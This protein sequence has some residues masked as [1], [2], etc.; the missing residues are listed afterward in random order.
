MKKKQSVFYPSRVRK[1]ARANAAKFSWASQMSHDIVHQAQPWLGRTDDE[2]WG[3]MFGNTIPRS[4]MVWSNGYCPA[5][6]EGVPMYNWVIDALQ[7]PWKV[8]CPHCRELFP[9]NDFHSF[10]RSG[11]DASG[12]FD[13]ER[14]DRTLLFNA[15]HPDPQDP[16][17]RFGVDEGRGYAEGENRW[18]FIGA[19]LIYGQWKQAVH[20]GIKRLAAAYVLSGDPIY[21]HKAGV[22]LDRVADLYPTFDGE[23]EILAYER[24]HGPGYVSTWHDA[25]VETRDLVLAY[26]QIFDAL[27][28]DQNLVAFLGRKAREHSLENPKKCI[29][30][31]QRNIEERILGDAL[32]NTLAMRPHNRHK[33]MCN[34]P[35]TDITLALIEMV[36]GWPTNRQEVFARVDPMIEQATSVDGL[37]G[38]K[39]LTGYSTFTIHGLA[40]FLEEC[41]RLDETILEE[42]LDRHPQL[43]QTYRFHIDTWCL[44]KYYPLVGDGGGFGA[45][46]E[47]YQG[48]R[49]HRPAVEAEDP[50]A[51]FDP[52]LPVSM[53]SLLWR[54]YRSTGDAAFIQI[55]Y[56]ANGNSVDGLPHDLLARDPKAVQ[57]ET[58]AVTA[59][60]GAIP[61]A[62]SINKERWHLAILRSGRGEQSRAAWV[63]YCRRLG[64]GH[65]DG[66]NLGLF[67]KGLDLMPDFGY[68]PVQ[69]GGWNSPRAAWYKMSAAHNTVV[70]DGQDQVEG[71]GVTTLWAAGGHFRAI[72]LSGAELIGGRQFERTVVAVDISER[73]FY[74][75]DLFRVVGGTDHA[76]FMHSH[77]G[78]IATGGLSLQPV[79]EYGHGTQMRRFLGDA[80]PQ[81]G[82]SVDWRVEDRFQYLQPGVDL[83]LRYTD[84]T[85]GAQACTCEG[86]IHVGDYHAQ[87]DTWIPR[88][89]VRR[90]A[91]QAPLASTF[92]GLI[93][94]YETASA[95][96][97]VRRLP[98]HTPAGDAYPD[99]HVAV[100][101]QLRDGRRDLLVAADVEN[102]LG[103]PPSRD[104]HSVMV[105]EEWGLR[106]DGELC[107]VR[108]GA[109]GAVERMALCRGEA[110]SVGDAALEPAPGADLTDY[111]ATG[112]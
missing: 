40:L 55:L 45:R 27:P 24:T 87:G 46:Y 17:H 32:R 71:D 108:V 34:F 110:L 96:S 6:R 100:E 76:K 107:L 39:G 16:L 79:Q 21:A 48:M 95:V 89:M 72:R 63:H 101:V 97:R 54:L 60:E 59:R 90:R 51:K 31:V 106:L 33:I 8:R 26:D 67:A 4:W 19:Y 66:M 7:Q 43:R 68:P 64:H 80:A 93:E 44:Q 86:W 69:F 88:V 25:C 29:A 50:A 83:H 70:V 91:D 1:L 103:L 82:W 98:L 92:V 20:G 84:L 58:A 41:A 73:D 3:L 65:A 38:E 109:A 14:A 78:A 53:Y 61:E 30:D 74:L 42:L 12:V 9:K 22:L 28:T 111:P 35:H 81:P 49:F 94:P 18:R 57:E 62:G 104:E 105:Q 75:V 52:I 23:R 85:T 77:F 56:R 47:Q 5:C 112:E 15:E 11:L 13:P 99:P 2:L 36:L 102:P 10:Y 37:T